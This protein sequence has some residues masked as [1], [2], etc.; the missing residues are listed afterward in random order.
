MRGLTPLER[1]LLHRR[2][3]NAP[4]FLIWS[5]EPAWKAHR[6]LIASGRLTA[7]LVRDPDS[8]VG[9]VNRTDIT[10]L[11]RLAL[12]VCPVEEA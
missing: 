10:D 2:A 7:K 1:E 6:V 12:R 8:P 4:R 3:V 5:G 9:T 11:G